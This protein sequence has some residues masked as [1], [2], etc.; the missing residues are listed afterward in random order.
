MAASTGPALPEPLPEQESRWVSWHREYDQPGSNLS[1]RLTLVQDAIRAALPEVLPWAY[2]IVSMCAGDGRDVLGILETRHDTRLTAV[3]L[4]ETDPHIAARAR[5]RAAV[6]ELA[7]VEVHQADAGLLSSY[8]GIVP[9]DLVLACGVFGN[10]ADDEVFQ[11]VLAL[12]QLCRT[13][14]TVIWTRSRVRDVTPAI[15]EAFETTGFHEV[16]FAA[17]GDALWSVGVARYDG[18]SQP[19]QRDG[20]MF[21]LS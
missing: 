6:A 4:I 11:T 17:P 20:R 1:R 2:R 15:R 12:P 7:G 21:T 3:R 8:Q 18:R 19:L 10:I 13:G 9:A 16:D 14:A 5:R